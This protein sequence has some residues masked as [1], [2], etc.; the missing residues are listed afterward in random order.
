MT[1]TLDLVPSVNLSLGGPFPDLQATTATPDYV[2]GIAA[3]RG[4]NLLPYRDHDG[5]QVVALPDGAYTI[6]ELNAQVRALMPSWHDPF[7]FSCVGGLV[8][9]H[10]S[11]LRLVAATATTAAMK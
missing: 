6:A 9:R 2:A 1:T 5:E 4:N 3:A 10:G 11:C 8:S 7:E